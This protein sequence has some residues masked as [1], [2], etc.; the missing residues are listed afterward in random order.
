MPRP[1]GNPSIF[2]PHRPKRKT[3]LSH[4]KNSTSSSIGM[5]SPNTSWLHSQTATTNLLLS[6]YLLLQLEVLPTIPSTQSSCSFYFT[7]NFYDPESPWLSSQILSGCW[8]CPIGLGT[9]WSMQ[10]F[11]KKAS[12][13]SGGKLDEPSTFLIKPFYN[14]LVPHVS[15]L[16]TYHRTWESIPYEPSR[17]LSVSTYEDLVWAM[18]YPPPETPMISYPHRY[19][20]F[21]DLTQ[22][23]K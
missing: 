9:T 11:M 1:T 22:S 3:N 12:S 6:P 18:P 21:N 15:P 10:V 2:G 14:Q 19:I 13:Y 7:Q 4:H 8:R 5:S 20:S 17:Y 23:V 16:W